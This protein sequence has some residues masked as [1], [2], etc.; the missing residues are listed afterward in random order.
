MTDIA[1]NLALLRPRM[2][3]VRLIAVSKKQ[4]PE[5]IGQ[6]LDAGQ[7]LFGEN[8]VQ[9]AQ[10]KFTS[11]RTAYPDLEL[12]L[13]GPLQ[14]NKALLAVQLFDVI[15]TLDRPSLADALALAI[16]QS[17]RTPRLYIEV[18]IGNEPQKAGIAPAE[19]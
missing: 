11:L 6:A 4:D 3:G 7:R 15:Q 12:H 5:A 2:T 9:E 8:R 19:L 16:Q 1:R 10:R 18:N 14:T 17:G 13:I